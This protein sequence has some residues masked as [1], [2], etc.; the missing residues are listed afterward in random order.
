MVFRGSRY[1]LLCQRF[2]LERLPGGGGG[3][4]PGSGGRWRFKLIPF[5]SV[6]G[7]SRGR[8]RGAWAG[9]PGDGSRLVRRT[10]RAPWGGS[11]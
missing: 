6:L 5:R 8:S 1:A 3:P 9:K 2:F 4:A 10:G 11:S 7:G